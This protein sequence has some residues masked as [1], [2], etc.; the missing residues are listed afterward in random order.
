MLPQSFLEKMND[1]YVCSN[2]NS[3]LEITDST[4]PILCNDVIDSC[5]ESLNNV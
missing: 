2:L 3:L 1:A 4:D 5:I